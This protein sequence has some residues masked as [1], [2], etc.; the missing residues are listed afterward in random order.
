MTGIC[1]GCAEVLA[2][3]DKIQAALDRIE[4][5]RASRPTLSRADMALLQK[6]LPAIAAVVGSELFFAGEVARSNAPGVQLAR[7]ALTA[8]QVGRLLRRATGCPIAG[9]TV[10]RVGE[11]GNAVL[12]RIVATS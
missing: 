2:K 6:L 3:L 1:H 11:E 9:F 12:W 8:K 5:D 7:G 10:E 4:A